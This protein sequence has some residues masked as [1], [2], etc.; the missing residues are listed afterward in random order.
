MKRLLIIAAVAAFSSSVIA[1]T[2]VQGYTRSDGTYVQGYN[3][4][5][6]NSQRSDNYSSQGNTNP[7]T[8]K[9]GHQRNEYSNP[10]AYNQGSGLNTES[11]LSHRKQ[12]GKSLN[13]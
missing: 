2:Y 6:A 3:R 8:G 12:Q 13:R 4:T 7:Y 9:A 1:D 5:D 11:S 10:P